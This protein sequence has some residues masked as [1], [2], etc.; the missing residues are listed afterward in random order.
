MA[1]VGLASCATSEGERIPVPED[2]DLGAIAL[3]VDRF[4][5]GGDRIFELRGL[6]D[7]DEEVALV[8]L[9]IGSIPELSETNGV[10]SELILAHAQDE[11]RIISA[12]VDGRTIS[13][14]DVPAL[15][16][17]LQLRSVRSAL[18]AASI[19]VASTPD[20]SAYSFTSTATCTTS[21]VL[22]SPI[23]QQCCYTTNSFPSQGYTFFV[24]GGGNHSGY[25][26][27]RWG[28]GAV[29]TSSTGGSC[30]GASCSFGPYGFQL[31]EFF[32]GSGT[33]RVL[34]HVYFTTGDIRC[35]S[36]DFASNPPPPS[37]PDVTGTGGTACGCAC[38]GSGQRCYDSSKP[39]NCPNAP[40]CSTVGCPGGASGA[41]NWNY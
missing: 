40:A 33:R 9:R 3:R 21:Q 31:P 38:D 37:Y 41:G 15:S 17:F 8:R 6:N 39:G 32:A 10:G 1:F 5:R 4:V 36:Q 30:S 26:V 34:Q 12:A 28:P 11:L 16:T 23:A 22:S 18:Q 20:E 19:V 25:Y 24:A 7:R 13:P 14:E 27:R 35:I 29:C 2:N